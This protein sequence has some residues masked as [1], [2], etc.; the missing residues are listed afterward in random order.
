MSKNS[1]AKEKYK[2]IPEEITL[3]T[4][5]KWAKPRVTEKR[6]R[7]IEGVAAVARE[8]AE[9]SGEDAFLAELAGWLHDGC[10]EWKD[11]DLVKAAQSYGMKLNDL[12]KQNGH[13]LHGPV[14]AFVAREELGIKHQELLDAVSEHT[15]GKVGMT[16]LSKVV[17]LADCLEESRPKDFTDP[18]WQALK[19][20]QMNMVNLDAAMLVACDLSLDHLIKSQRVIHIKTVDVRN[21]FLNRCIARKVKA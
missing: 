13:L 1:S 5:R 14:A 21:Y 16:D 7:H 2:G 17:F 4:A 11:K 10:K 9:L 19:N 12:E 3:Q 8:I 15:L 6:F 20:N 18:I